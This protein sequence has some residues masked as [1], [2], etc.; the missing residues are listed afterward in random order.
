MKLKVPKKNI[1]KHI[2][3]IF[4]PFKKKENQNNFK[5][6][7][8]DLIYNSYPKQNQISNFPDDKN[9]FKN[10]LLFGLIFLL[11]IIGIFYFRNFLNLNLPKINVDN[12]F[13]SFYSFDQNNENNFNNII[14]QIKFL[15]SLIG[16][17]IG[18]SQEMIQNIALLLNSADYISKNW[19]DFILGKANPEDF[20]QNFIN[21]AKATS[22]L[23]ENL[24]NI[25]LE[26]IDLNNNDIFLIRNEI[27]RLSNFLNNF[28]PF[29]DDKKN[30]RFLVFFANTSEMRPGGGFIGSYADIYFSNWKVNKIDILDINQPDNEFKEKIIPPK[31]LQN[32]VLGWKAAD[33]NWFLDF[34]QS[35]AKVI[36][37]LERSDFYKKDN[38]QFEGAI[39][40][41]P[42][43]IQDLLNLTGPIEID[44]K[45]IFNKDNFLIE[46]QKNIQQKRKDNILEPKKILDVFFNKIVE[47]ISNLNNE[48]KNQILDYLY[49]W[50]KNKDL[51]FYFKNSNFQSFFESYNFT[52]Q[53]TLWDENIL[54]DYLAVVDANPSSGKS[55]IFIQKIVNLKIQIQN[56]GFLNNQL[57]IKRI[58][59]VKSNYEWW[60]KLPN[61]DFIQIFTPAKVELLNVVGG[62][63]KKIYPRINY[64]KNNFV[65]DNDL[66]YENNEEIV[67]AFPQIKKY[68]LNNKNIFATWLETEMGKT[69]LLELE[70][71]RN[72]FKIPQL[73]NEFIF[74]IDR[75][76][77]DKGEYNIEINAPIGFK[78][79]ENNSSVFKYSSKNSAQNLKISLTL[80]EDI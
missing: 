22:F 15:V 30:H 35:A 8:L 67:S 36:N 13:E 20:R 6:S 63:N 50:L 80:I 16:K 58:N 12:S 79:K 55:D 47:K 31:A 48:S 52:G 66:S 3:D 56:N 59:N 19:M 21:I 69:S 9:K 46:I 38:V 54:G 77:G 18:L 25:K 42:Q 61:K 27:N 53:S 4:P 32:I 39:L 43:V 64:Q 1:S 51:V 74:I 71:S 28:I 65:I 45:I 73:G 41:T 10:L 62:E 17:N 2:L 34:N 37:F 24:N 78:F 76:I 29:M 11:L 14:Q 5:K 60:Y 72:L 70:Y 75:Q 57:Q 44:S 23:K 40:I 26:N 68:N 33:A 7:N 49:S